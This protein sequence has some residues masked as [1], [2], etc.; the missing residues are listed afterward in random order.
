MSSY[1]I[2]LSH[3]SIDGG[4]EDSED[5]FGEMDEMSDFFSESDEELSDLE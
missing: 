2:D 4:F 1:N 3:G 5:G